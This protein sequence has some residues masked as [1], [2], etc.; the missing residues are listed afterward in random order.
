M[1][2]NAGSARKADPAFLSRKNCGWQCVAVPMKACRWCGRTSLAA[3]VRAGKNLSLMP[4]GAC[5]GTTYGQTTFLFG[6]DAEWEAEHDLVESGANLRADVL[7][8][9]H[10]GSDTSSSY[11]YLRSVMP[12][13]AIISVGANNPYGHPSEDV[14]SRLEDADVVVMRTDQLGTIVCTSDGTELNFSN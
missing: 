6:G 1:K 13:Y 9:N 8:V 10:H 2:N 12:T 3:V 14:L 11:V 5:R 4:T 7:K